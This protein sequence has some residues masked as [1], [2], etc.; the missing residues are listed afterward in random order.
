MQHKP[1]AKQLRKER[2]TDASPHISS[3]PK[4][5]KIVKDE[6]AEF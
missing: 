5:S 1:S 6:F 3:T 4:S 2:D